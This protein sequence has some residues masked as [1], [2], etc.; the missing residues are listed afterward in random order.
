MKVTVKVDYDLCVR[1]VG[2]SRCVMFGSRGVWDACRKKNHEHNIG[3]EDFFYDHCH[4][5][6]EERYT[7]QI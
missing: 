6:L 1:D 2:C 3:A 7:L 5:I 4:R